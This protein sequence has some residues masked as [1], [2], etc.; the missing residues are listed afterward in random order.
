MPFVVLEKADVEPDIIERPSLDLIESLERN[1]LSKS[2]A[3]NMMRMALDSS[4]T[5]VII[6]LI[7]V[8]ILNI[9]EPA[10]DKTAEIY[11]V[12]SVADG[13]EDKPL[14]YDIKTF[15]GVRKGDVLDIGEK[16]LMIYQNPLG[17]CLDIWTLDCK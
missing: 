7:K 3:S 4:I 12:Y 1:R 14:S 16:G 10:W 15:S 17:N 6:R 8:R 2:T 9:H 11:L 13:S 5:D